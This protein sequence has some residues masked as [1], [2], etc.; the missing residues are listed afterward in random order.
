MPNHV[1]LLLGLVDGK[2]L[3]KIMLKVNLT[4]TSWYN[5]RYKKVGHLWQGRYKSL[6]ILSDDYLLKCIEYVE[7]NPV[8][9]NI[10]LSPFSYPYSSARYRMSGQFNNLLDTLK[11][12]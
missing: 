3:S 1:H 6:A 2:I 9:A 10:A 12:V 8:R 11:E 7:S 5:G 4:Y